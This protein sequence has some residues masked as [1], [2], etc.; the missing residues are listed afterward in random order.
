MGKKSRRDRNG[1]GSTSR[2]AAAAA[3]ASDGPPPFLG[4]EMPSQAP[5]SNAGKLKS[6]TGAKYT[7][8]EVEAMVSPSGVFDLFQ[9]RD[10]PHRTGDPIGDPALFTMPMS[11]GP[12]LR[13]HPCEHCGQDCLMI[14][15]N[16]LCWKCKGTFCLHCT[17]RG[18]GGPNAIMNLGRY[19]IVHE[20]W[21]TCPSC[22]EPLRAIALI[23][24][25]RQMIESVQSPSP[26]VSTRS[27][28]LEEKDFAM[29]RSQMIIEGGVGR[30]DNK[31]KLIDEVTHAINA[32]N[33]HASLYPGGKLGGKDR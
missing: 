1:G 2:S 17:S 8:R 27:L 22:T 3:S 25:F 15:D 18:V 9:A 13:S 10:W 26:T 6:D 31:D 16:V 7:H 28:V 30:D 5:P 33:Y 21:G 19:G 23:P 11:E 14:H 29:A 12:G 4:E 24:V 20:G 32:I